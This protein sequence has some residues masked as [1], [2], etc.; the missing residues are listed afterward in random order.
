M[1]N[2]SI[3][4]TSAAVLLLCSLATATARA[5]STATGT[6]VSA[7]GEPVEGAEVVVATPQMPAWPN[8]EAEERDALG[9]AA[10]A[11]L[12]DKAGKFKIAVPEGVSLLSIVHPRSGYAQ[13][14]PDALS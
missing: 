3:V 14:K 9:K 8:L 4:F 13:L 7:A 12:T 11:T 10:A 1:T 6:V 5:D 2:R